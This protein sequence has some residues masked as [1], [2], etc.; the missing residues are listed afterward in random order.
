MKSVT[1]WLGGLAVVAIVS[2]IVYA[3]DIE[4]WTGQGSRRNTVEFKINASSPGTA[5]NLLPG[6]ANTNSIGSSALPLKDV[7]TTDLSIADDLTVTG[8]LA[9]TGDTTQTGK[10]IGVPTNYIVGAGTTVTPTS[11]FGVFT[12]TSGAIVWAG[13]PSIATT[14]ATN[15]QL[16]TIMSSTSS[17]IT[18][19]DSVNLQL[20]TT[21]TSNSRILSNTGDNIVLRYYS[22]AWYEVSFSTGH[23]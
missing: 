10:Y 18:L 17:N 22:G 13:S 7:Y 2:T 6:T 3:G 4:T 8:D 14:T 16:F 19:T 1:M 15:G 21:T 20:S 5:A 12:T 9:V 11:E 23:E